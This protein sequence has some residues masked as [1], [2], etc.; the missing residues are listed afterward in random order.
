MIARRT[1]RRLSLRHE[2]EPDPPLETH[3]VAHVHRQPRAAAELAAEIAARE[4]RPALALDP[5]P[6][7]TRAGQD[8]VALGARGPRGGAQRDE[9]GEERGGE[10]SIHDSSTTPVV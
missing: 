7:L 8:D 10:P 3:P 1:P 9:C 5:D 4:H 2:H 6:D